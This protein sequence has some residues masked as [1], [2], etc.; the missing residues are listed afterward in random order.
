MTLTFTESGGV[1]AVVVGDS[2]SI[3]PELTGLSAIPESAIPLNGQQLGEQ[4]VERNPLAGRHL[5]ATAIRIDSIEG[6][7]LHAHVTAVAT[8]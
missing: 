8:T 5:R 3:H 2:V 1:H 4:T 7:T 6:E